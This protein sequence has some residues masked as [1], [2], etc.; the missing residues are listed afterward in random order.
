MTREEFV[1]KYNLGVS[2]EEMYLLQS[3]ARRTKNFVFKDEVFNSDRNSYI[4]GLKYMLDVYIGNHCNPKNI[5][6]GVTLEGFDFAQFARDYES[7]KK[8][9]FE[10]SGADRP[11]RQYEGIG[12][13]VLDTVLDQMTHYNRRLD[14]V[15][16][17]FIKNGAHL[18]DFR[19][20]TLEADKN[21]LIA[22]GYNADDLRNAPQKVQLRDPKSYVL[23]HM[24]YRAMQKVI[25]ERTWGWRLNPFNWGRWRAENKFMSDLEEK[26]GPNGSI[27]LDIS[28]EG[29]LEQCEDPV[30]ERAKIESF[31]KFVQNAKTGKLVPEN[32]KEQINAADTDKIMENALKVDLNDTLILEEVNDN[33]P[34]SDPDFELNQSIIA[35]ADEF[36]DLDNDNNPLLQVEFV[37]EQI[38]VIEP[39]EEE[40][41]AK[42]EDKKE[43]KKEV[44]KEDKKEVKKEVKEEVKKEVNKAVNKE[45]IKEGEGL[46]WIVRPTKQSEVGK[47]FKDRKVHDAVSRKFAEILKCAGATNTN[48]VAT[49]GNILRSLERNIGNTWSSPEKMHNYAKD[50]FQNAY[51]EINTAMRKASVG[52]K[53][54]AAQRITD[55]MLRVYS[56]A[57]FDKA[58]FGKYANNYIVS[59]NDEFTK[60]DCFLDINPTIIGMEDLEENIEKARNELGASKES[61][62]IES[63][64]EYTDIQNQ[65]ISEEDDELNMSRSSLNSNF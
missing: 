56:P 32:A 14:D 31:A 28:Q 3:K 50:M 62:H 57:G 37:E 5:E 33:G 9:E 10:K 40:N 55:L 65:I 30:I 25:R 49:G 22:R 48:L 54:V 13:V 1:A 53:L 58:E 29:L 52:D 51:Y 63:S 60:Q 6:F 43:D 2:F 46:D 8:D 42:K 61:L 18:E 21:D 24:A 12:G 36:I 35:G 17:E 16:A 64:D 26:L 4:E 7:A 38:E 47:L 20:A 59:Q 11:R 34:V 44:K 41:E 19:S 39:N 45:V 27:D 15:W 23:A